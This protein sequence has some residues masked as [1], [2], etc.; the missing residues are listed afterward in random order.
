MP[1]K[2]VT[3]T[4]ASVKL[5]PEMIDAVNCP[6]GTNTDTV[7]KKAHRMVR[8]FPILVGKPGTREAFQESFNEWMDRAA[9]ISAGTPITVVDGAGNV[10][11]ESAI[12]SDAVPSNIDESTE[13]ITVKVKRKNEA[14]EEV[15]VEEEQDFITVSHGQNFARTLP[16]DW[17]KLTEAIN[18][19]IKEAVRYG[20]V[21]QIT[22][23]FRD[24]KTRGR[25][26]ATV[27]FKKLG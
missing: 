3:E 1:S 7:D 19:G 14:G 10:V 26:G 23:D 21:K 25:T 22:D 12:P 6:T 2:P 11:V 15:E 13:K 8:L 18:S 27:D 5:T 9:A 4:P 20:G 16:V 17:A 24:K